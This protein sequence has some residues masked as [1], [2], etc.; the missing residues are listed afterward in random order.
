[1]GYAATRSFFKQ[2]NKTATNIMNTISPPTEAP[3]MSPTPDFAGEPA[4]VSA[5]GLVVIEVRVGEAEVEAELL[6]TLLG[7][8]VGVAEGKILES[9]AGD[10]EEGTLVGATDCKVGV[11]VGEELGVSVVGAALGVVEVGVSVVGVSV[12]GVA[13]LGVSVLGVIVCV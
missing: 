7:A 8:A 12:L 5:K 13:E 6:G 1:M 11:V 3:T 2:A 10:P 4:V 9:T